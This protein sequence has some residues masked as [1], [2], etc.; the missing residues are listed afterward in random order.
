MSRDVRKV[1]GSV[2][3]FGLEVSRIFSPRT[4]L[5][6]GR[7]HFGSAWTR[8]QP[9]PNQELRL[10]CHRVDKAHMSRDVQNECSSVYIQGSKFP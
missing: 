8:Y 6:P 9:G 10:V 3:H 4:G 5:T 1:S 2:L 7:F